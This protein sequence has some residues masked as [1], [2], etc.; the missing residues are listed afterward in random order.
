MFWVMEWIFFA[1][2]YVK[3]K[4][5]SLSQALDNNEKYSDLKFCSLFSVFFYS[6]VT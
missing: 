3:S 4:G 5:V 6:T 1:K 2:K